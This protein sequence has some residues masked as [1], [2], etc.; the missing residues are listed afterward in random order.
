MNIYCVVPTWKEYPTEAVKSIKIQKQQPSKCI[1]A[2]DDCIDFPIGK[3]DDIYRPLGIGE[4]IY[5][6]SNISRA[7]SYLNEIWEPKDDDIIALVDGD[8]RL[9]DE[10]SF[11]SVFTAHRSGARVTYGSYVTKSELEAKNGRVKYCKLHRDGYRGNENYRKLPWRASHLKT[12]RYGL[13]RR[14]KPDWYKGPDGEPLRVCSDLALMF[15]ML[16][17]AGKEHVRHIHLPLYVYNDTSEF[18]VH[19]VRGEE[20]KNIEVWLRMQEPYKKVAK[21]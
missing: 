4:R 13:Y 12:F 17:M 9:F 21:L 5:A 15:P 14:L 2:I 20:Q 8:D 19:K 11:V 7:I 10:W 6:A 16:E 1:I 3:T 18:N